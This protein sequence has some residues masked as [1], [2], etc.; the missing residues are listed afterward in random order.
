MQPDP[1]IAL[2]SATALGAVTQKLLRG[3]AVVPNWWSYLAF[4][5][6]AVALYAWAT[7]SAFLCFVEEKGGVMEMLNCARLEATSIA[8]WY[9]MARGGAATAKDAGM[10]PATNSIGGP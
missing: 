10:A 9:L 5:A 1:S 7:P 6:A 2:L 8:A 4:G 3:P